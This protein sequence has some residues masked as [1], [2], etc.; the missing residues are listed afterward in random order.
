MRKTSRIGQMQLRKSSDYR[1]AVLSAF[2][3]LIH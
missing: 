2:P 3:L 1:S